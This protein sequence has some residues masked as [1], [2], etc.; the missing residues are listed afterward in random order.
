MKT[1]KDD[2]AF[3]FVFP[4]FEQYKFKQKKHKKNKKS[5]NEHKM[6]NNTKGA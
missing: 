1:Q 2:M 6:S 5:I 4:A 3:A